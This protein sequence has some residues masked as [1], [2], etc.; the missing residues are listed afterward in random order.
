MKIK[1]LTFSVLVAT[2]LTA[3]SDV[4]AQNRPTEIGANNR[5]ITPFIYVGRVTNTHADGRLYIG[6]ATAIRPYSTLTCA[7]NLWEV[8]KGWTRNVKFEWG[9][10]DNAVYKTSAASRLWILG[11]YSTLTQN[12]TA[13]AFSRDMAIINFSTMPANGYYAGRWQN[14]ALLSTYGYTKMSVGY[15]VAVANGMRMT[16][17]RA[18][19]SFY[20][21]Y[22]AAYMTNPGYGI[23][24]GMSGGPVMTWVNNAW[25][26][27][28]VNVSGPIG[29]NYSHAGVRSL[30]L[31]GE[32]F[33]KGYAY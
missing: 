7:H 24:G 16:Q 4:A 18:V 33:V 20:N 29:N 15:P 25:W 3:A 1:C 6:S 32:N 21:S 17:S 13:Y 2:L 14:T 9:R 11:G 19:T 26:V 31:E 30:D 12:N 10:Y 23:S 27:T 28:G 8:G 5:G 22:G